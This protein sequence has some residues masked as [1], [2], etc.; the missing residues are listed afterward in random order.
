MS[1]YPKDASVLSPA[2]IF[3]RKALADSGAV[4]TVSDLKGKKIAL[5]ARGG[6]VEYLFAERLKRANLTIA[7]IGIEI[8]SFPDMT[9][10]LSNG[11][12][13]A[14]I[15]PEPITTAARE[16]GLGVV[17]ERNP[18][19]GALAQA[20]LF[21]KNLLADAEAPLADAVLRA[22]RRA[23]NELQSPQAIMAEGN[24]QIYSKYTKVPPE[25]IRK[26]APYFFTRDLAVDVANLMDQQKYLVDSGRIARALPADRL[27]DRRL[28]LRVQ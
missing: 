6:I 2:P 17:L 18:V 10:A 8:L 21:G 7:D 4:T 25:T 22:L 26:T 3:V 1:Y 16:R 12:I 9:I 15:L 11:I 28:A 27:V 5:N 19:P 23:G 14:A 20:L 13:D 24:L